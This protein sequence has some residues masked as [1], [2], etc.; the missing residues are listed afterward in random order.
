MDMGGPEAIFSIDTHYTI[1]ESKDVN[2]SICIKHCDATH[3]NREYF[4][5][6]RLS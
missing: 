6:S 4:G 3:I 5:A 2:I 1:E